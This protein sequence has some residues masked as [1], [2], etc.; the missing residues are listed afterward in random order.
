MSVSEE[1][2]GSAMTGKPIWRAPLAALAL[3][4]ATLVATPG[5]GFAKPT[6]DGFAELSDRLMPAVVNIATTQRIGDVGEM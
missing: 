2:T 3:A 4:V 6:P 5:Q 1:R